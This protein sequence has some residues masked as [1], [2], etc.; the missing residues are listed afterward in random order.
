MDIL[1]PPNVDVLAHHVRAHIAASRAA[2]DVPATL[3]TSATV[4][5]S[6]HSE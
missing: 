1:K 6:S 2:G 4:N 5:E 3:I